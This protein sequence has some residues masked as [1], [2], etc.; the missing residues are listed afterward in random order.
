VASTTPE[1][2]SHTAVV[3]AAMIARVEVEV[4]VAAGKSSCA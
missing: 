4:E 3:V 1:A 2:V